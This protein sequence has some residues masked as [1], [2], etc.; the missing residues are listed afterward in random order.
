MFAILASML[1]LD[2]SDLSRCWQQSEM[3]EKRD[4]PKKLKTAERQSGDPCASIN[5]PASPIV[6]PILNPK[7]VTP[8]SKGHID[9]P[10]LIPE[11]FLL[12]FQ[13]AAAYLKLHG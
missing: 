3:L 11:P 6:L 7:P 1:M 5:M 13:D 8:R 4:R 9:T 12:D 10:G 2:I